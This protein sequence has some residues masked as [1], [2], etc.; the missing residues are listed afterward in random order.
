MTKYFVDKDGLYLGGF[1]GAEPP[2]GSIEVNSPPAHGNDTW[3]GSKWI[4][5][6]PSLEVRL[7]ATEN[8][9]VIARKLEEIADSIENGTELSQYTKDWLSERKTLR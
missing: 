1:D 5:H 4:P 8:M 3:D 7:S 2:K 9:G 6:T